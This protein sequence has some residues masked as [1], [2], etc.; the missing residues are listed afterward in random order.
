MYH[1]AAIRCG[2]EIK[3]EWTTDDH[4]IYTIYVALWDRIR[5][6]KIAER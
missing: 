6:S 5:R 3:D 2:E 1:F 4:A